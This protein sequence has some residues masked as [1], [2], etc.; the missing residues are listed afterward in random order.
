[1]SRR[2]PVR[3]RRLEDFAPGEAIVHPWEVTIDAG[4]TA[5]FSASF[6]E[7]SPTFTSDA[8][9]RA[10]GLAGR[11][12]H[13]LLLL[14]LGLSFSVED[15]SERAIAHLSYRDVRFPTPCHL[16]DTV[17]AW[18]RVLGA[19]TSRRSDRGVVHVA[20]TLVREDGA[21][22]CAFEREALVRAGGPPADPAATRA[23]DPGD[24]GELPR[25]P[26][27]R[28]DAPAARAPGPAG[29]LEDFAVGDVIC[30][31]HGRTVGDTEHMQLTTLLRNT[32]PLHLDESYARDGGSFTGARVVYGGL[33]LAW[34]A[35]LS[36]RDVGRRIL[37]DLGWDHG[38]HPASVAAG[39][40]LHAA[41]RIVDVR[42]LDACC[43]ELTTRLVGLKNAR[44]D[45]L[46]D[47]GLD[48]FEP[49]RDR[50][51][52]ARVPSKVLEIT[53]TVLLPRRP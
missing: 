5:L 44:P 32:H 35:S 6:L 18:S 4:L 49:E 16:G 31:P 38:A 45:H 25:R 40:T 29:F 8:F 19:R 11:P 30:H 15:V 7:A 36:S 51:P 17:R 27:L 52:E 28:T 3:G 37:W 23:P 50:A 10:L 43:G 14:N 24:P 39:D 9:A 22:V 48:L 20:T 46:I 2:A 41:S 1:M 33:V 47:A 26:A 53:R 13:P 12:V 21:I 34:V 42:A